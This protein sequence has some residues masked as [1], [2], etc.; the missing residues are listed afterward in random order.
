LYLSNNLRNELKTPLGN[1]IKNSN[2]EKEQIIRNSS[3]DKIL[4]TVG[5]ATSEM[6][7]KMGIIPFLQVVDG[8]EKRSERSLP[9]N[10]FI[11]TDLQCENPAGEI[12]EESIDVIKN[13][14]SSTPPIRILVDGEE[15]LLVLPICLH[16]PENSVVMYGQPD[17]GLVIIEIVSELREKI[18]KIVNSMK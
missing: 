17:Q 11:T 5:D 4:I 3:S 16:A 1:L 9:I 8:K 15:D 18:Q 7:V 2:P 10:D 13:S 14:F 6:L 12:T